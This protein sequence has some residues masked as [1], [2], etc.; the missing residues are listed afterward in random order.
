VLDL[1]RQQ[2]SVEAN[3][4]EERRILE[5]LVAADF[6]KKTGERYLY[7]GTSF[8]MSMRDAAPTEQAKSKW[9]WFKK[10]GLAIIAGCIGLALIASFVVGEWL[11]SWFFD[12]DSREHGIGWRIVAWWL[13]LVTGFVE[14]SVAVSAVVFIG[15]IIYEII[16]F[17]KRRRASL[18]GPKGI[19][20]WLI[21]PAV[22]LV[23]LP[24]VKLIAW[25]EAW[26]DFINAARDDPGWWLLAI[27]DFSL[28]LAV[29]LVAVLFFQKRPVAV[30]AVVA[31]LLAN[32]VINFLEAMFT[33]VT[34]ETIWPAFCASIYAIILI[35]YFLR[36]KRVKNTFI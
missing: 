9:Q 1:L 16:G 2:G 31:F 4:P 23:L 3:S 20:G 27:L 29:I 30:A 24:I 28:I 15:H 33:Q 22:G 17:W 18:G 8:L 21:V 26:P 6:A 34:A 7:V 11:I 35:P 14:L 10:A 25:I 5:D 12:V 32:I 13:S 19:G 36:S